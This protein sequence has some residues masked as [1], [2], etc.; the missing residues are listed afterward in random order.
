MDGRRPTSVGTTM[1]ET[2]AVAASLGLR[3]AVNLDGGGSTTMAVGGELVNQPSGTAER[4][5]ADALVYVD[6]PFDP[7]R[8][9]PPT[10]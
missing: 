3:E 2:A 6:E 1:A 5:V 9:G 10:A 8:R 4:P 7:S